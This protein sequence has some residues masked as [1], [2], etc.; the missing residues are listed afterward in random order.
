[1][2]VITTTINITREITITEDGTGN[3]VTDYSVIQQALQQALRTNFYYILSRNNI[4]TISMLNYEGNK[5]ISVVVSQEENT[6]TISKV[7]G[8]TT[9][10]LATITYEPYI[11][12]VKYN[13]YTTID[14]TGFSTTENK[15]KPVA[16]ILLSILID[17]NICGFSIIS[18]KDIKLLD[19][20]NGIYTIK[21]NINYND[22]YSNTPNEDEN[23]DVTSLPEIIKLQTSII[24]DG[25]SYY[26]V[27]YNSLDNPYNPIKL[28]CVNGIVYNEDNT[29]SFRTL[30]GNLY[31]DFSTDDTDGVIGTMLM[32]NKLLCDVAL[33]LDENDN[34]IKT[35]TNNIQGFSHNIY[36]CPALDVSEYWS[37]ENQLNIGSTIT[38]DNSDYIISDKNTIIQLANTEIYGVNTN[39][40]YDGKPH[41]F[42][43]VHP[44][45]SIAEYRVTT[46]NNDGPWIPLPNDTSVINTYK[47]AGVYNFDYKVTIPK[48]SDG[49][50]A[51]EYYGNVTLTIL[52]D[53]QYGYLVNAYNDYYDALPH[54]VYI[55]SDADIYFSTDNVTWSTTAPIFINPGS[56]TVYYKLIKNNY[57]TV[58]DSINLNIIAI[59][60]ETDISY[61][62]DISQNIVVM[63]EQ[64]YSE[65]PT[66]LFIYPTQDIVYMS[67]TAP[68]NINIDK[69]Y[70]QFPD[71]SSTT[72][73]DYEVLGTFEVSPNN[74]YLF[75]ECYLPW[76]NNNVEPL[77]INNTLNQMLGDTVRFKFEYCNDEIVTDNT[78]W[79]AIPN[80]SDLQPANAFYDDRIWFS[81]ANTSICNF[82]ITNINIPKLGTYGKMLDYSG[83]QR[84]SVKRLV[85]KL[86]LSYE[87]TANNNIKTIRVSCKHT[88]NVINTLYTTQPPIDN[89]ILGVS[90]ITM[91]PM[92]APNPL[93]VN[94]YAFNIEGTT[95]NRV[96][97]KFKSALTSAAGFVF[98]T[99]NNLQFDGYS[100]L[101]NIDGTSQT[102][103]TVFDNYARLICGSGNND[104]L[105]PSQQ[106]MSKNWYGN[107][108]HHT[109]GDGSFTL[110]RDQLC[111]IRFNVD[112]DDENT[113]KIYAYIPCNS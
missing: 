40:V 61:G 45:G 58:Q 1:M 102:F 19:A 7:T 29:Y 90:L 31:A 96:R 65:V 77:S 103:P 94:S 97:I 3:I 47:D 39:V 38:I 14:N 4:E 73:S 108:T 44:Y 74:Y 85:V 101:R 35:D 69:F 109:Y 107:D 18:P 34:L 112:A 81:Y 110:L 76:Y 43:I 24:N 92:L 80:A 10:E 48:S 27:L 49:N 99:G 6:I 83:R 91:T 67:D 87:A 54:T 17:K 84:Q 37:Q 52:E 64:L 70:G 66:N 59:D 50:V 104:F 78:V 5:D 36:D 42:D 12:Y 63:R 56:Y 68:I 21:N 89:S 93:R 13:Q 46:P 16:T 98:N 2:S 33:S 53:T 55:F 57:V 60:S 30:F 26:E 11:S 28:P 113:D 23:T 82:K 32:N 25:R 72:P 79:K 8:S 111:R 105:E 106:N 62:I 41:F 75:L 88:A 100:A 71:S 51:K 95:Y 86:P 22:Y 15:Y 20:E 9:N